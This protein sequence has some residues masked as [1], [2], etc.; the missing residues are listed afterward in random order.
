ME[1]FNAPSREV[2]TVRRERTNTPLQALVTLNDPQFV[3]AAR[4]LAQLTLEQAAEPAKARID[5]MSRRLLARSLRPEELRVVKASLERLIAF[6]QSHPDDATKLLAVG[7][8]EARD[9]GRRPVRGRLDHAGQRALESGRSP[10]QVRPDR[11]APHAKAG[12]C[13][14]S[15][16]GFEP[17]VIE[18]YHWDLDESPGPDVPGRVEIGVRGVP[19]LATLELSLA[20]AVGL[21]AMPADGARP[22]GI[23]RVDRDQRDARQCRLVLRNERSWK[24]DQPACRF[25]W[26]CLTVI[27]SRIPLRSSRAIAEPVALALATTCLLMRWF[28]LRRKFASRSRILL[29]LLLA[30]LVPSRLSPACAWCG[31]CGGLLDVLAGERLAV[32]VRRDR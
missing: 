20:L 1:M 16:P 23:A 31:A 3:E 25:R 12:A 29:S 2:C 6:Y 10:E 5:F 11:Q 9:V 32:G 21:L 19:T 24:N 17:G 15:R 22:A 26:G 13:K 8:L 4:A 30:L 28:S 27:R 7:E 18:P 14:H